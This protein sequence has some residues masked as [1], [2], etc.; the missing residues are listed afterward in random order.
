MIPALMVLLAILDSALA[1]FRAAAGRD[2]RID[3]RGYFTRAIGIGAVAGAGAVLVLAAATV[4]VL[5]ASDQ[6]AV[7]YAD[8]VAIGA[9]ML[10]V[11]VAFT[12]LLFTALTLYLTSRPELRSLATVAILGPFTLAR[13]WVVWAAT[14]WGLVGATHPLPTLALTVGSSATV[15][16]VGWLLDAGYARASR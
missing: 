11:F 13:P 1:G 8:L 7:L 3:K 9:R 16:G 10:Q 14:A 4:A 5:G 12:V 15:L 6:P 2:A